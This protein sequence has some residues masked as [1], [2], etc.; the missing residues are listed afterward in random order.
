MGRMQYPKFE[1][2]TPAAMAAYRPT[3]SELKAMGWAGLRARLQLNQTMHAASRRRANNAQ[4][5]STRSPLL[6]HKPL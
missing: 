3:G 5:V 6:A 1:M 4:R 2:V